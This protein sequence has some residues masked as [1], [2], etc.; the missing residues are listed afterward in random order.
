MTE[1]LCFSPVLSQ[2]Y[3]SQFLLRKRRANSFMEESK[4]GN[5]ERECI[6]ELCN[7]EEAREIFEN[8]PETVSML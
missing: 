7:R 3:A 1:L 5:L 6:E 8:N 2:Q 4:K